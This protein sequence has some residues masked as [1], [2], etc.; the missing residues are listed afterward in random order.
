MRACGR[1]FVICG[2]WNIAHKEIDVKNWKTNQKTT[3]SCRASASGSPTV[4][5]RH[6]FVDVLPRARS[7]PDRFTWWNQ[8]GGARES[9]VG[10]RIDY[11]IATPEIAKTAKKTADLHGAV[12]SDHA[13]LTVDYDYDSSDACFAS[14]TSRCAAAPASSRGRVDARAS[15]AQ[16]GPRRRERQRQVEPLRAV[17]GELHA[18]AGEVSMPPRWVLSHVAQETPAL[19]QPALEFVMDGDEELRAI[20]RETEAMPHG[21]QPRRAAPRYDEIGGYQA[22][23]RAQIDARR[24]GIRRADQSRSVRSSPAAGACA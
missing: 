1:E 15:R 8:F 7:Q 20:E 16:G 21:V 14:T 23:S 24:P 12:F 3:G 13:P 18:D 5:E 10:W 22:R 9:N 11:Q 19:D 4:L 2:D 6:G 17:R